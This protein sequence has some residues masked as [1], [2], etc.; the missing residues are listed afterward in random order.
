MLI[1][2]IA[3]TQKHII[4]V[5]DGCEGNEEATKMAM[6]AP[7]LNALDYNVFNPLEVAPEYT[8]DFGSRRGEA[9]DYAILMDGA[10]RIVI[11]CKAMGVAI[12]KEQL[13]NQ[14]T[15]YYAAVHPKVGILT[16]GADWAL[17]TDVDQSNVMDDQPFLRF[18]MLTGDAERIARDMA[19]FA[20][21]AFSVSE[22]GD[23]ARD[24]K[25]VRALKERLLSDLNAPSED[26]LK[27]LASAI[28]GNRRANTIESL[29]PLVRRSFNEVVNDKIN[30]RLQGAMMQEPPENQPEPPVEI[31][32]ADGNGIF[33]TEEELRGLEIVREIL[34][35]SIDPERIEYRDYKTNFQI[36]L[37]DS[38]ETLVRL[39]FGKNVKRAAFGKSDGALG[40]TSDHKIEIESVESLAD[41]ADEIRQALLQ[42]L[43]R[44]EEITVNPA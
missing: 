12:E 7:V 8:A 25:Y 24:M 2:K 9:V 21:G 37:K 35:D 43:T 4:A 20:K 19:L 29:R 6:I 44:L 40:F 31:V 28:V 14:L 3:E 15:R 27:Y 13:V 38:N 41:H 22:V 5:A 16:N 26:Y 11:E 33:T 10:P 18:N 30:A 36:K 34:A 42:A 17:Y 1:D 39:Y 23:A 32:S